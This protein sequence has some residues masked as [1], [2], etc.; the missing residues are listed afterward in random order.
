MSVK[1]LPTNNLFSLFGNFSDP[2]AGGENLFFNFAEAAHF[3]CNFLL[4]AKRK[5]E[6]SYVRKNHQNQ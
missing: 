4:C 6:Q 2:P 3:L 5:L 1:K